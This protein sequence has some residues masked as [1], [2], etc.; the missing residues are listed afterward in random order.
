[1]AP[2]T[3]RR[4]QERARD[5]VQRAWR[6]AAAERDGKKSKGLRFVHLKNNGPCQGQSMA[7]DVL[8]G[9]LACEKQPCPVG[10]PWGQRH[11]PTAGPW[12]GVVSYERG[13]SVY[14]PSSLGSGITKAGSFQGS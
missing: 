6:G 9:Y 4:L 14:V 3:G 10:L 2:R 5:R 7:L 1:M 11:S 12:G 8:Q 13:T